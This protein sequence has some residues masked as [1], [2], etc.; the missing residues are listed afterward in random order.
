MSDRFLLEI[1]AEEI[2]GLDDRAGA[3]NFSQLF[4]AI[5]SDNNLGGQVD[6][7]DATPR[8]LV[9]RASGL[10]RKAGGRSESCVR[11]A[12]LFR[13]RGGRASP[14]RWACPWSSSKKYRPRRASITATTKQVRDAR[15]STFWPSAARSRS[16]R[17]TS[18]RRCTGPGRAEPRFIRPIRW[19]VALLGDEVVPFEIAGVQ[20]G[21]TTQGHRLL[22]KD[23]VEVTIDSFADQLHANGVILSAKQRRAMIEAGL[24]ANVHRDDA[25]LDDAG[26]PYRVSVDDPRSFDRKYLELPR[27]GS[28]HGD[29]ASPEVFLG[30]DGKASL[31]PNSSR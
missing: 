18:R 28:D 30:R 14:R 9:L 20:S 21:S 25:L 11:S 4:T 31:R 19:I 7:L 26:L 8:R 23:E 2:P 15:Q 29:A 1:G 3:G 13:R 12:G 22:G 6:S 17:Y 16:R 27:R 5:L 10:K 24:G